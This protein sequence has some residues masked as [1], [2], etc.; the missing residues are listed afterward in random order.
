[1]TYQGVLSEGSGS[2]AGYRNDLRNRLPNPAT[3]LTLRLTL[4]LLESPRHLLCSSD[5][6]WIEVVETTT[7]ASSLRLLASTAELLDIIQDS[8]TVADKTLSQA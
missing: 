3:T 5:T 4:T 8:G 1:M 2:T 7:L 6:I